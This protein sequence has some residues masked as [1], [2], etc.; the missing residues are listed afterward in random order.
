MSTSWHLDPDLADRY[1]DGRVTPVLAASVEQHLITCAGCR[2]LLSAG[3]DPAR[4]ERV[5]SEVI[6]RVEDPR[7]TLLER[8]LLRVGV[9]EAT[10]RVI[11]VTPMLR[12]AWLSGVVVLLALSLLVA[13]ASPRGVLLF[14]ALAPVMPLLG[15]AAAFGP[16]L[17]RTHEIAAASPYSTNR[18]L[19]A[20]TG[21]VAVTA[22][23]PAVATAF[24]LPGDHWIS[25]AW[26][27]PCV[28]LCTVSLAAAR[29]V[30]IHLSALGMAGL[31]VVLVALRLS[32]QGSATPPGEAVALQVVSLAVITVAAW[33][34]LTHRQELSEQLRSN[35]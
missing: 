24:F 35:P 27:L 2:G 8:V 28:A 6:E 31:W 25:V 20:R 4:L 22:L 14:V 17:D 12:G 1:A 30:P 34:V 23:V 32:V 19:V 7:R 16:G 26:L 29:F 9:G 13:H 5:W 10:A 33:S 21:F 15:V 3:V 18:L 11:A